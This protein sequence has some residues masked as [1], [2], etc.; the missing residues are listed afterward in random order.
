[1]VDLQW[2]CGPLHIVLEVVCAGPAIVNPRA[3]QQL[4]LE[5]VNLDVRTDPTLAT[6]HQDDQSHLLLDCSC[7]QLLT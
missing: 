5:I 2:P 6:G 7:S 4:H 3:K 1:V